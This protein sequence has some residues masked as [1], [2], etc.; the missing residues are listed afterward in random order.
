MPDRIT[1]LNALLQT[2]ISRFFLEEAPEVFVTVTRVQTSPD[3]REAII[4]LSFL[5]NRGSNM[6]QLK[7]TVPEMRRTLGQ[8]LRIKYIPKIELRHDAGMEYAEH[9]SELLEESDKGAQSTIDSG[10][11]KA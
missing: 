5:T 4:W 6:E 10:E 3:L 9:I 1:Q 8:R 7:S 11:Q 2:E